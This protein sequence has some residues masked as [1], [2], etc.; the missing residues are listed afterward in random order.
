MTTSNSTNF[1]QTRNDVILDA[2]SLIG[3][4]SLGKTMAHEDITLANRFLNKMIKAWS[5]RGLHLWSKTEGVL[6][7]QPY[8]GEYTL[9]STSSDHFT[10]KDE[11]TVT[12]LTANAAASA[13]SLT[14]YSTTGMTVADRIGI[15]LNSGTIHWTTIAT[16]PTSTTLTISSGLASAANSANLIF[17]Y[18]NKADKPLRVLNARLVQG[19]DL[20]STTTQ[21]EVPLTLMGYEQFFNISQLTA[22]GIPNQCCYKPQNSDGLFYLWPRPSSGA[23]RIN[24]TYERILQDMD[25]MNDTFDFPSEWLECLTYQ[26]AVRLGPIYGK[27]QRVQ[28]VIGPLA[29]A[30]LENLLAWDNE[31]A[32]L[33]IGLD[34]AGNYYD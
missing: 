11:E 33:T 29:S 19:L 14:V 26:L 5:A 25:E 21:T 32:S 1:S 10:R 15:V 27:D 22:N 18:T 16:I 12:K 6:Y 9:S 13:T 31:V 30:F 23:Y 4:N 24:L 34:T 2:F 20:S 7:L 3:L 28:A 17:S 8:Q